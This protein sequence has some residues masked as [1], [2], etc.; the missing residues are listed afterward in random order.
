MLIELSS[1]NKGLTYTPKSFCVDTRACAEKKDKYFNF[2][3]LARTPRIGD[4][5]VR[6]VVTMTSRTAQISEFALE[7]HRLMLTSGEEQRNNNYI[8]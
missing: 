3:W 6:I 5:H 4:A 2:G 8:N 7:V 1:G